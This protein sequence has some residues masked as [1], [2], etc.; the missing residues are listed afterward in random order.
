MTAGRE[1]F[2][3]RRCAGAFET[4]AQVGCERRTTAGGLECFAGGKEAGDG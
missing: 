3:G 4:G 1:A 2:D